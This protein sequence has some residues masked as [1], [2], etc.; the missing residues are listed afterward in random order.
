MKTYNRFFIRNRGAKALLFLCGLSI[1]AV[2][3]ACTKTVV[4]SDIFVTDPQHGLSRQTMEKILS[5]QEKLVAKPKDKKLPYELAYAYLQAVRENADTGFYDRTE[6]LLMFIEQ[7]DLITPENT[8]LRGLL[9]MGKHDF[10][11]A[12]ITAKKLIADHPD[13][14]R[15]YVLLAD[16]Q[17]E[18]GHYDDAI[19]TLQTMADLHPDAATLTRIAYI[20]EI[21][22]D[23]AGSRQA[24]EEAILQRGSNEN[25]A[26]E[27]AELA[28]L[29]LPE[30]P[31]KADALYDTAL[32]LFPDFTTAF[33]GKARVSMELHRDAE[34][35]I[36]FAQRAIDLLP[37]P[38]YSTILGD[39]YLVQGEI[40]K[41]NAQ[42]TLVAFGYEAI[43]KSGINVSLEQ[44]RFLLDHDLDLETALRTAHSIFEE[45]KTIYTA[46]TLAWALYKNKQVPEAFE[47]AQKALATGT[48][49]PMILFHAALIANANGMKKEAKKYANM[50][51]K[52]SPYF[53]FV[54][55]KE[56]LELLRSL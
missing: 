2:L 1:M 36:N 56:L 31:G 5:I 44:T 37:L 8:F 26:W 34:V 49:D 11:A 15:Y 18:L 21:T 16:S 41:A 22:G 10:A 9:Q 12:F 25:L 50:L 7:Q 24:M 40:E 29:W 20:R 52:E 32:E 45:R 38:E 27:Y 28:R 17:I 30:D 19:Q 33:A 6:R 55:E 35:A 14:H 39:I 3:T 46:D 54:H 53:S 51:K 23:I 43:A 47:Y 4:F 48:H 13:V 42:Y